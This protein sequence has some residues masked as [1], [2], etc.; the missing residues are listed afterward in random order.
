MKI[1]PVE[2]LKVELP[3]EW[4]YLARLYSIVH[5]WT[6]ITQFWT[7][8]QAILRFELPATKAVFKEWE[9]PKPFSVSVYVSVSKSPSSALFTVLNKLW[10][11][12]TKEFDT[13]DALGWTCQIEITHKEWKN[14]KVYLNANWKGIAKLM[15]GIK[16]PEQ[17]NPSRHFWIDAD[18]EW[19]DYEDSDGEIKSRKKSCSNV[20]MEWYDW[21]SEW[22]KEK[23]VESREYN[24]WV[25]NKREEEPRDIEKELKQEE[26][27]NKKA[28]Q[29]LEK[30]IQAKEED[31]DLPF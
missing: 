17:I 14:N 18:Y 16:V 31:E 30:K 8:T 19:E 13:K 28:V 11:D 6:H 21:L 25:K 26:K 29:D 22:E 10:V 2:S 5:Q 15:D 3:K 4:V 23:I 1:A 24:E 20:V 27:M 12:T 9:D 7:Q